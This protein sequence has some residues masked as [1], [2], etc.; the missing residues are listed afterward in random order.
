MS[1]EIVPR[2]SWLIT[3]DGRF[4]F[5]MRV[6]VDVAAAFGAKAIRF[7]LR[8]KERA[9]AIL[10]MG[11]HLN[12]GLD[13][14]DEPRCTGNAETAFA[15][16]VARRDLTKLSGVELERPV[17]GYFREAVEPAAMNPP[18]DSEARAELV[19]EWSDTLAE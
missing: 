9:T 19:D 6:P 7:N 17:T 1:T 12:R 14:F 10:L 13:R 8:T 3:R 18:A 4:Y 5:D 16:E 2:A 11:K 15:A